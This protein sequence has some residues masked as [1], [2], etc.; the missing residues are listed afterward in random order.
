MNDIQQATVWYKQFWPWFLIALP[1]AV[2]LAALITVYIASSNPDTLIQR[3]QDE[4][5]GPVV[6]E[7]KQLGREDS[8]Q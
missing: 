8:G 4:R 2:V 3:S 6:F 5:I 1:S 7:P